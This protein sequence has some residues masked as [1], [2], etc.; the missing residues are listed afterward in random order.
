MATIRLL[1]V[2]DRSIDTAVVDDRGNTPNPGPGIVVITN[3]FQDRSQPLINRTS[4][5]RVFDFLGLILIEVEYIQTGKNIH[6]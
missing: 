3:H 6:T 1:F 5:Y 2:R 4:I